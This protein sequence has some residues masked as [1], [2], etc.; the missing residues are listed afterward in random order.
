M[1]AV[2]EIRKEK[3][4]LH[5]KWILFPVAFIAL[6][7]FVFIFE[8]CGINKIQ[9]DIKA[10]ESR[11]FIVQKNEKGCWEAYHKE[12]DITMVYIEAGE[13]T[14][15]SYYSD[16]ERPPHQ[17]YLDGYWI[18]KYEITFDQ[19]DKY[20]KEDNKDKPDDV[21][22]GRGKRPVINVTWHNA[23]AY[24]DWL[25]KKIGL[26]FKLPTEAQWEK[27]AR[28]TDSRTYPWGNSPPTGDKVN[29]A[30]KQAW[31]KKKFDWADKTI[32]DGYVYT[33]PVGSFPK[34][35]SPYG[36]LDMA[37]NVCEWCNDWYEGDYYK[38]SPRKNPQGLES[39]S[40]RVLRGGCWYDAAPHI[41]CA[42]RYSINPSLRSNFYGFRLCQDNK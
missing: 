8:G 13:F 39:G 36:L 40:D 29:F 21:G 27:A 10:L 33:A 26:K 6:I 12:Y 18:G 24:C 38:N 9:K 35:V 1:Q 41:R 15:G 19:Y 3:R 22:W 14:M 34:G 2:R 20:C 16:H 37:G 23:A 28:G 11:G 31:L 32:D 17:V 7:A 4:P 42:F 30:D 25:S 5:W